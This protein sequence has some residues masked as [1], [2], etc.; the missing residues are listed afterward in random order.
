MNVQEEESGYF[1]GQKPDIDIGISDR[2]TDFREIYASRKGFSRILTAKR[3]GRIFVFKCLREEYASDPVALAAL[4]KEYE[5][6]Y[7]V[8]SPYV[9]HTHD[10]APVEGLGPAIRLEYCPGK[11]LADIIG[12][13]TPLDDR[14]TDRIVNS[15]ISGVS[16]IHAVGIVHRD[17]KP[18]NIIYSEATGSLRIID[19]GSA[20]ALDFTILHDPSGTERFTPPD[21]ADNSR[22]ADAASDFYAVGATLSRLTLVA[23]PSRKAA[24]KSL[25]SK[26]IA[27]KIAD[28]DSAQALYLSLISGKKRKWL[29]PAVIAA[30]MLAILGTYAW[31]S[32]GRTDKDVS[33][34]EV[35]H[36]P[37]DSLKTVARPPSGVLPQDDLR[38]ETEPAES[39]NGEVMAIDQQK[40]ESQPSEKKDDDHDWRPFVAPEEMILNRYGVAPAE[41][42]YTAIFNRNPA[43][44]YAVKRTDTLLMECSRIW[45]DDNATDE[46]KR[47]AYNR[48]YSQGTATLERIAGEVIRKYPDADRRRAM[49]IAHERIRFWNQTYAPLVKNP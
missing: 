34:S 48:R 16:D 35:N 27:G 30:A 44:A 6:G 19:F 46:E 17:I 21:V 42:K 23:S 3:S 26:M 12:R 40:S 41:A 47:Q 38:K 13:E 7:A 33:A 29:A 11:T 5:C 25:A 4:R 2:Y 31:I 8:D 36:V 43:D 49:G 9:V 45:Y 37:E 15:L 10:F 1:S 32:T 39:G 20:D 24:L 14:D 22:P 18:S 28:R